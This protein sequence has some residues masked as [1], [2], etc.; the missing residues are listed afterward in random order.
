MSNFTKATIAKSDK[1]R[2]Q[3]LQRTVT[4]RDGNGWYSEADVLKMAIS[5]L[6]R[7]LA[8]QVEC[9]HCGRWGIYPGGVCQQCGELVV[10][11]D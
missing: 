11:S 4:D 9:P 5:A 7:E 6:E 10:K 3:G 1:P 2:L 8:Q